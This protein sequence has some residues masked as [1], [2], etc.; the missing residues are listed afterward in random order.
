MVVDQR[1]EITS[2][3]DYYPFGETLRSYTVS[4]GQND[5]YKFTEK[6]RDIETGY[7]YFGARYYDSRI[8]RWLSVDPLADKYPGWSPYNYTLNNPINAIDPDGRFP[9]DIHAK[10]ITEV[11]NM[12][13]IKTSYRA[14]YVWNWIIDIPLFFTPFHFDGKNSF[15]DIESLSRNFNELNDH[16]MGDFYSHSNYVD[17]WYSLYPNDE[18]IPTL[19]ELDWDSKFGRLLKKELWTADWPGWFSSKPHSK[20]SKDYPGENPNNVKTKKYN[21][22]IKCYRNQLKNKY[23]SI[24][25][26]NEDTA[27][28]EWSEYDPATH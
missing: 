14:E 6:E 8:G 15:E 4:S 12:L 13:G 7:D 10:I 1:G 17:L 27:E 28:E 2:A 23:S 9:I 24:I 26:R 5:K 16:T 21:L 22:A 18:N 19:D 11:K 3:Q 20:Y 25:K